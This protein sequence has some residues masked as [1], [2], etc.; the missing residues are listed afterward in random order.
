[1]QFAKLPVFAVGSQ[2]LSLSQS[3]KI[4]TK[5]SASA[6]KGVQGKKKAEDHGLDA[7]D[8]S[9]LSTVHALQS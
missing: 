2:G 3:H 7:R 9:A 6:K 4:Q 1:M 8:Q 5:T